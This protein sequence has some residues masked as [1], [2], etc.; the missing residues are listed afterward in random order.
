MLFE[1]FCSYREMTRTLIANSHNNNWPNHAFN[2][3][4]TNG[5]NHFAIVCTHTNTHI[6]QSE[7]S[8]GV[9]LMINNCISVHVIR[10]DCS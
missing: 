5:Q 6:K 7:Y 10:I 2:I 9:T 3:T 8:P 1:I 4:L